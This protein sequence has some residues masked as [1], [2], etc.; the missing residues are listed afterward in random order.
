MAD[1]QE[2]NLKNEGT[3]EPAA[4]ERQ[5]ETYSSVEEQQLSNSQGVA[6]SQ[7]QEIEEVRNV[8]CGHWLMSTGCE[9]IGAR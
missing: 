9:C 3:Q 6:L 7:S 4:L 5:D 1:V 8:R 2:E